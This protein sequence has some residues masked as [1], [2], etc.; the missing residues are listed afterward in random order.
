MKHRH[1]P[2]K[3]V[4]TT[5]NI[6]DDVLNAIKHEALR[7]NVS[8]SEVATEL[9]RAGLRS[10]ADTLTK[11]ATTIGRFAIRP[12]RDEIITPEHLR[13]LMEQEGI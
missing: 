13:N 5:L 8:L 2:D 7:R 10:S 9:I 12:P 4:R 11:P 1:Q 3:S 6:D